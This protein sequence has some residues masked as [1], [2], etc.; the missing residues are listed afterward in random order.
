MI[1]VLYYYVKMPIGFVV[2]ARFKL[3]ISYSTKINLLVEL[4]EIHV[5]LYINSIIITFSLC[6]TISSSFVYKSECKTKN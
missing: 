5:V 4:I 2:L 6:G 3:E 1:I